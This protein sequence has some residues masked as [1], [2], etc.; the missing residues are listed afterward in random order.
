MVDAV[1][2]ILEVQVETKG[3]PLG[4]YIVLNFIDMYPNFPKVS[5]TVQAIKDSDGIDFVR[6]EWTFK[7]ITETDDLS[8]YDITWH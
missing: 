6:H 3:H 4:Q 2:T 8:P 1:I 7:K 5:S